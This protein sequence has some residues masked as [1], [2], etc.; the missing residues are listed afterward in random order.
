MGTVDA[1]IL[2]KWDLLIEA[3]KRYYVDSLPTGLTDSEYDNLE[4]LAAREDNFFVRDWVFDNYMKGVRTKNHYIDKFKKEKVEGKSMYQAILDFASLHPGKKLY[5]D[6][7]YDG[8]SIAVYLD[9][10]KGKPKRVIT[11]GNL[12][13]D[14]GIDQ[15]WK[16]FKFLPSQFPKGI[17]AI[18][19]EALID[20]IRLSDTDPQRARQKA[21]GLINSKYCDA[22]VSNLLT[23]RAYRYYVDDSIEGIAI[24]EMDYKDVLSSFPVVRSHIDGHILFSPVDVFELKDLSESYCST[25]IT[26]TTTGTFLND[27][28]V[29]YDD[30]GTCLG[31]LKYAGAGSDTECV[32]KT[33]VRSIQWNDQSKK[34]KDSWSANVI[35]DPVSVRGVTVKKP[36]AGSVSKLVK[37]NITPGSE[38]SIVLANST[39]PMVGECFSPG[40]GDFMWPTCSCGYQMSEKDVYGSLLKCGN[41]YCS[42]RI[43]RM[44]SYVVSLSDI[45]DLDLGILLVVDRFKWE[46]TDADVFVLLDYVEKSDAKSYYMYLLS[47]MKTDLQKRTLDLV[48]RASYI[49]LSEYYGRSVSSV[50]I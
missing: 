35:I 28:W 44:R 32:I 38:I 46:E 36:S 23:L 2:K 29:M 20:T 9:P 19:C 4:I 10:K 30:K 21:S 48:W 37:N 11:V 12:S 27:G 16:L 42:S 33:K 25:E 40:N 26:K 6:L 39:I 17:V 34:G 8:C 22:E 43:S 47:F 13:R 7:K 18:Q 1:Q 14:I 49:V 31:A 5:A 24:G 45:Y 15:T 3:C 50:T 41:P